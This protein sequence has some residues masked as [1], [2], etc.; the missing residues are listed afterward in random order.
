MFTMSFNQRSRTSHIINRMQKARRPIEEQMS[1]IGSFKP[2]VEPEI[3][4]PPPIR[5]LFDNW[6]SI[7][8]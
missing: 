2:S 5:V 6:T 4:V 8:K 1:A 7:N 3:I